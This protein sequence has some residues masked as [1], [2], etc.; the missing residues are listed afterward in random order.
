[1]GYMMSCSRTPFRPPNA[2]S[3]VFLECWSG[4]DE[5]LVFITSKTCTPHRNTCEDPELKPCNARVYSLQ[6]SSL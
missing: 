2:M 6:N 1:M 4:L 5:V 3:N